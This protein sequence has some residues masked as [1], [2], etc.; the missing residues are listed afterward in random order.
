[1]LCNLNV[2]SNVFRISHPDLTLQST[3][4][5]NE[6]VTSKNLLKTS[7]QRGIRASILEQYPA[8]EP[9]MNDVMPKKQQAHLY[10]WC[11]LFIST[12]RDSGYKRLIIRL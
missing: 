6:S 4:F 2:V 7:V 8:L 5:D 12:D 11:V 10:K 9:Y 3:R 1:M